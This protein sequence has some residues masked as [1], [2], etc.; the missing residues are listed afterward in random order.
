MIAPPP[1]S[2]ANSDGD[3][4]SDWD[5]DDDFSSKKINIKIKPIAQVTPSKISASVDELRATVGTWKS[6]ANINLVKPNSRRHHQSTLQLNNIDGNERPISML[7]PTAAPPVNLSEKFNI[8]S[9]STGQDNNSKNCHQRYSM[10]T[11]NI[12]TFSGIIKN[13]FVQN[14]ILSNG[15][16]LKPSSSDILNAG[17]HSYFN[18]TA[19]SDNVSTKL[20]VAI[21]IQECLNAKF[22]RHCE[23]AN[24]SYLIGRVKMAV[25]PKILDKKHS[26]LDQKLELTLMSSIPFDTIDINEEFVC[27]A[28]N[29][30]D[31]GPPFLPSSSRKIAIDMQAVQT[32]VKKQSLTQQDVRYHLLPTLLTYGIRSQD[33]NEK[34][35]ACMYPLKVVSHWLCDLD[36]TKVRVDIQFIES[37]LEEFGFTTDDI[38]NLKINMQ[39]DGGVISY[40]SK[41]NAN[42]NPLESRLTWSFSN[43]TELIQKSTLNSVT[44]CL[45]RFDLNDGP[46]APS[47]VDLQFSI[48][49]KTVSGSH[50]ILNTTNNYLIIKQ[51][52]EVRTGHFRC[53]AQP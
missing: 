37:A 2:G 28:D 43:L 24:Q 21:A 7:V 12:S 48:A 10:M 4:D 19:S 51:K 49:G 36:I 47:D 17:I 14:D 27:K 38:R 29:T 44:S 30:T 23:D 18:G 31:S 46:S 11:D 3:S 45:A 20:P 35:T 39:L 9:E 50:V 6:L 5:D 33:K 8:S 34:P 25:P 22:F 41:P 40:Q 52:H 26:D 13:E 15:D 42:W 1:L 32:F 16:C 53:Q